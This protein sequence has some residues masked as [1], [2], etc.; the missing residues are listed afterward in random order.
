MKDDPLTILARYLVPTRDPEVAAAMRIADG[1]VRGGE[2]PAA[3]WHAFEHRRAR[4]V[5]L[6]AGQI[7]MPTDSD[8]SLVYGALAELR[9]MV[10]GSAT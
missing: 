10:C 8:S 2:P 6:I 7:Q 3:D 4:V 1:V 9:A 5:H